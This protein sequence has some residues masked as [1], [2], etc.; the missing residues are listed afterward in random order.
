VEYR[1]GALV[2]WYVNGP[3]GLEQGLTLAKAPARA[4]SG[5][6][7][8][9]LTLSDGLTAA[10]DAGNTGL[11]RGGSDGQPALHYTGLT[12]YDATGRTLRSWLEV[13]GQRLLVHVDA[14]R[15]PVTLSIGDDGGSATQ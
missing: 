9:A 11:V 3:S 13:R 14:A 7:T 8:L 2:E 6:L 15:A 1:R 5:T 10:V 12:A 4:G